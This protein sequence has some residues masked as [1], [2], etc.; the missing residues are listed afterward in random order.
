MT[1]TQ[2]ADIR[3]LRQRCYD[4]QRFF[5]ETFFKIQPRESSLGLIPMKLT[6]V[7][8]HYWQHRTERTLVLKARQVAMSSV[9]NA[10]FTADAMLFP[11]TAVLILTQKPEDKMLPWHRN[12]VQTFIDSVPKGFLPW[13][14]DESNTHHVSF[15]WGQKFGGARSHIFFGSAGTLEI[16]QGA[17]INRAH[18]TEFSAW[19]DKEVEAVLTNLR[20]MPLDNSRI[21]IESRPKGAK[22]KFHDMWEEA[23]SG[24]GSYTGLLYP[25]FWEQSY[26]YDPSYLGKSPDLSER[27]EWLLREHRL[28]LGQIAWRRM[29]IKD[30]QSLHGDQAEAHF[31]EQYLEDDISC[32]LMTGGQ[33]FKV[34]YLSKLYSE[35]KPPVWTSPDGTLRIWKQPEPGEAYAIGADS[36]LGLIDSD[37]SAVTVR[38]ARTWEHVAT[39]KGHIAPRP[40]G[41]RLAELG[42]KYNYALI[43]PERNT[44]GAHVIDVLMNEM[45]YHNVYHH[46]RVMYGGDDLYGFPTNLATKPVLVAKQQ[47]LVNLEHMGW[48]SP[49]EFLIKQML[50]YQ[51]EDGKY[52]GH[53]DDL[54]MA[55]MLCLA[56]RE[57]ALLMRPG[58]QRK[59]AVKSGGF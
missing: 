49:D 8:Q 31:L 48:T 28:S 45:G 57:Q 34:T 39:I 38:N 24:K 12:R 10:E 44:F 56:G 6:K 7:Q 43:T 59:V 55:D 52:E 29:Q 36:A 23:K 58:P 21:V 50:G 35:K 54:V 14:M 37:D 30:A 17:T 22:G 46:S 9:V 1:T 3:E 4:D 51:Q 18:I 33:V 53:P 26:T 13:E 2:P 42:H 19:E 20:G 16:G 27:E 15:K 32:F 25:W 47:Q 40:F 41:G 5:I 11:G